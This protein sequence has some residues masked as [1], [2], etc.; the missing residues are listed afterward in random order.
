MRQ[1]A[2]SVVHEDVEEEKD[3]DD[4]Q[5]KEGGNGQSEV[6]RESVIEAHRGLQQEVEV[7]STMEFNDLSLETLALAVTTFTP[8][9]LKTCTLDDENSLDLYCAAKL[10]ET[11]GLIQRGDIYKRL[12]PSDAQSLVAEGRLKTAEDAFRNLMALRSPWITGYEHKDGRWEQAVCNMM[13]DRTLGLGPLLFTMLLLYVQQTIQ[14]NPDTAIEKLKLL[15]DKLEQWQTSDAGQ[16]LEQRFLLKEIRIGCRCQQLPTWTG[17]VS[18]EAERLA[19]SPRLRNAPTN[20]HGRRTR[21]GRYISAMA[22]EELELDDALREQEGSREDR[23][24]HLATEFK[25]YL[26][27][28]VDD[29]DGVGGEDDQ[30]SLSAPLKIICAIESF[31]QQMEDEKSSVRRS[32]AFLGRNGCGKSFLINLALQV[33][34][35]WICLK[36]EKNSIDR[37]SRE[38]LKRLKHAL[39]NPSLHEVD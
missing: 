3:D 20:S 33:R 21:S 39:S 37:L 2:Q 23:A 29:H 10:W 18:V 34:S 1:S 28:F 13:Q 5:K 31:E 8:K 4:E 26:Q 17:L 19:F 27:G 24:L 12:S 15:E 6:E 25:H 11:S 35:T 7:E 32:I 36:R 38:S 22:V 9:M 14:G 16:Q 30:N